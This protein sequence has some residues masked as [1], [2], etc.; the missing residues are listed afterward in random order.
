MNF[1]VF[2]RGFSP[3]DSKGRSLVVDYNCEIECS[4]VRVKPG[5]LIFADFEGIVVIPKGFEEEVL[6]AAE[7]KFYEENKVR[8]E[9]NSG[10]SVVKVFERYGIL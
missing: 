4:G 2:A 7:E 1:P 8:E 10:K 3:N 6:L 5:D 9:L